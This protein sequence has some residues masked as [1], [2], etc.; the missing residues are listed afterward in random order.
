MEA[1]K[2]GRRALLLVLALGLCLQ[3]ASR[4]AAEEKNVLTSLFSGGGGSQP[5]ELVTNE[6]VIVHDESHYVK[7]AASASEVLEARGYLAKEFH[8]TTKDNY[9]I[10]VTRG[11]NPLI[12]EG[13]SG[14]RSKLPILFVH[15]AT[16]S[17]SS[18]LL[19]SAGVKP[20]V[21]DESLDLSNLNTE[22]FYELV[23]DEPARWSL[24]FLA[25]NFGYEIWVMER[26]G[27]LGSRRKLG[28]NSRGIA[29]AF[30]AIPNSL[31]GNA[32][33]GFSLDANMAASR[34]TRRRFTRQLSEADQQQQQQGPANAIPQVPPSAFVEPDE[35]DQIESHYTES[36]FERA[37]RDRNPLSNFKP[38][39]GAGRMFKRILKNGEQIRKRLG[40]LSHVN[41]L[42]AFF[43]LAKLPSTFAQ[44]VGNI[45]HEFILTFDPEFWNFSLDEQIEHDFPGAVELVLRES[46]APKLHAVGL[47]CGGALILL[48][49]AEKPELAE[50]MSRAVLWAPSVNMGS[51]TDIVYLL[52]YIIP[53]IQGYIGPVP[54]LFLT[55]IIEVLLLA[56]C[57]ADFMQRT[58]CT[59][60]VDSV[61]GY[62]GNQ[63]P[64]RP[65][66]LGNLL[67]PTSS[68]ELFQLGQFARTQTPCKFT[69]NTKLEN[70]LK[71]G[72]EEPPCYDLK[73]VA[74]HNIS[75]YGGTRDRLV[76]PDD[77]VTTVD[78]MRVPAEVNIIKKPHNFNHLGC[79]LHNQ[80]D[81]LC[82]LPSLLDMER[83]QA[84]ESFEQHRASQAEREPDYS[85][86]SIED[87]PS[88]RH[89]WERERKRGRA[90]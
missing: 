25:L 21:Y 72:T 53:M 64:V 26:R 83:S 67:Q 23:A 28:Q 89:E 29:D 22:Q 71:Y 2:M 61:M 24:P 5:A 73:Q 76:S 38:R 20:R 51:H 90:R 46:G 15:G 58:V 59:A 45:T 81:K 62:T 18:Y 79:F 9:S 40:P 36:E 55:P 10:S 86:N 3:A 32:M 84:A 33:N 88:A 85:E 12:N 54:F 11:R 30:K 52:G 66:M 56:V 70:K 37:K 87:E 75:F 39:T 34:P 35:E 48:A 1:S 6:E 69:M 60:A 78:Q 14:Y 50:R 7:P 57:S 17:A 31:L 44:M 68:G 74:L 49:L 16:V 82:I 77:I 27:Y 13:R 4:A 8:F 43:S 42:Q 65:Y 41:A 19:N 63:A 80:A 47:S